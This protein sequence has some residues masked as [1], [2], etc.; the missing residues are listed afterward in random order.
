MK[1]CGAHAWG[2]TARR[3]GARCAALILICALAVLAAAPRLQAQQLVKELPNIQDVGIEERR[4]EAVPKDLVFTDADGRQVTSALWFDGERPVILLMAYYTCPLLCPQTLN[5][6]QRA[7]NTLTWTAGE[8]YRIVTVSFDF[9]DKTERASEMQQTYLAGYNRD[10]G[11]TGWTFYTGT[12][13]NIRALTGAVGYNYKFIPES[14]SFSHPTA[15]VFLT[16]EGT[17]ST[18]LEKLE[19][20]SAEV[21]QALGEAADG[22]IGTIFDRVQFFC[23]HYDATTGKYTARVM[24]IMR[25]GAIT[26]AAALFIFVGVMWRCSVRRTHTDPFASPTKAHCHSPRSA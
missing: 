4:G 8:Q 5:Q 7:V 1:R 12:T 16:P 14:D 24:N 13:E 19:F 6:L 20:P 9:R 10:P 25:V 22:K 23:F 18:Y 17:V 11:K 2:R 15:L 3:T 26:G 21:K